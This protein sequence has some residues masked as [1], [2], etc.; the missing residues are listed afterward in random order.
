MKFSSS[1]MPEPVWRQSNYT[2]SPSLMIHL[3]KINHGTD[4]DYVGTIVQQI[5]TRMFLI[6]MYL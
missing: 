4:D 2:N 6:F 1:F 3:K 5:K